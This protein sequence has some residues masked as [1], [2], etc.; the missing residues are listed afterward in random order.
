MNHG[1]LDTS[2]VLA[3]LRDEPGADMVDPLLDGSVM[4]AANWSGLAQTLLQHGADARQTT[5]RLVALGLTV[6]AFTDADALR[7]AELWPVTRSA[8]LSLG[9]RA[10]LALAAR[11][12]LPA[13]TADQ[14]WSNLDLPATVQT[15]R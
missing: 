5:A 14:A 9:D 12:E 6:E 2:A 7:A 3:W 1:V 13:V 15:I 4:G 11:L 8:G 10:C